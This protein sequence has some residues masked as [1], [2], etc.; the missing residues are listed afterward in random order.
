MYKQDRMRVHLVNCFMNKLF[1]YFHD[2]M[3]IKYL[4]LPLRLIDCFTLMVDVSF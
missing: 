4:E 3:Y 1:D 2:Y